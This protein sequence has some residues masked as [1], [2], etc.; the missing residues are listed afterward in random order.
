MIEPP[1]R[2]V[3]R[4]RKKYQGAIW[5]PRGSTALYGDG[6]WCKD[7]R[8]RHGYK[9]MGVTFEKKSAPKERERRWRILWLCPK[10]GRVCAEWN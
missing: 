10:T 6:E 3:F 2:K 8:M 7:C 9:T 5:T 4:R 1:Y